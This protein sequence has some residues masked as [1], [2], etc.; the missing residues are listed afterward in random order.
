MFSETV[1]RIVERSKRPDRLLDIADYVNSA[2]R[3][4]HSERDFARDS[5]ETQLLP[6]PHFHG[7]IMHSIEVPVQ[8]PGQHAFAGQ[9]HG[10]PFSHNDFG[11]TSFQHNN[12][13]RYGKRPMTEAYVWQYPRTLRRIAAVRYDQRCFSKATTPSREMHKLPH[14]HYVSGDTYVFVGW[15]ACIDV[16]WYSYPQYLRYFTP[17][18]RPAVFHRDTGRFMYRTLD[19][20]YATSLGSEIIEREAETLVYDWMLDF[21]QDLVIHKVLSMLYAQLKDERASAEAAVA[22]ELLDRMIISEHGTNRDG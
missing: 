15:C 19:G 2:L 20:V 16:Y 22:K 8:P 5:K 12:P 17:D 10:T 13:V 21:W 14:Y 18:K 3:S 11:L 6:H 4:L 9:Q 7:R 1:D